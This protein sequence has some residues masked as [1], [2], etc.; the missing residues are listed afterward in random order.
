QG[1]GRRAVQKRLLRRHV[2]GDHSI[3]GRAFDRGAPPGRARNVL[4]SGGRWQ[5]HDG[6][7]R[8]RPAGNPA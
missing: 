8:L 4:A 6:G 3:V 5:G 2:R 7:E 1:R